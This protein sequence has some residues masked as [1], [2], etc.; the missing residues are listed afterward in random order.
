MP[1]GTKYVYR[2]KPDGFLATTG[3]TEST[4][5]LTTPFYEGLVVDV[6]LDQ[7]HPNYSPDGY[8][9]GTIK[10]RLLSVDNSRD[11]ELLDWADPL[12]T[13]IQEMPLLGELVLVQKVLGNFFYLRKTNLTRILQEHGMLNLNN[14]ISNRSSRL[15]SQITSR[16]EEI[17]PENHKFGNYFKPD[18]RV[19]Q[20][21]HFEGDVLIQGRMGHSIRFGSSQID[22]SS[23]GLAPN[24]LFRT[25]QAKDVENTDC[26][27]DKIFGLIVE[28]INKDASSVWMTSDQV[29]P[30]E[31]TI[32]NV[33]S[34]YRSLKNPPQQYDGASIIIN[35]DRVVLGSKKTHVLLFAQEE[36][37]LNSFNNTSID[38][39]S[40]IVLTANIDIRNLSSRNIDNIADR[41]YTINVGNDTSV[42]AINNVS[43]VSN[44]MFIGSITDD[45]EPLVGGA[46]LSKWLARL[47]LVLMG[48]PPQVLPWTTQKST[49]IPAIREGVSTHTHVITSHGPGRLNPTIVNGLTQL[50]NELAKTNPGQASPSEFAGAPFNSGDNFV[51]LANEVPQIQKNEFKTGNV[52][53]IEN[54]KWLLSEPY[55]KVTY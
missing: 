28:D 5:P 53:V 32:V 37:Y 17:T 13:T 20:L 16:D 33:G 48:N 26:T 1:S 22:P 18:N 44:K 2:A 42:V 8:N 36:I 55:Y 52:T 39:D 38:T 3:T 25:G 19:R 46:S 31:P 11:D 34:F 40:S 29:I 9:V 6:V 49:P 35:S 51:K 7:F 21:K 47:I 12:D 43:F 10:V 30:Y 15:R 54:N 14:Q 23:K 27:T 50:Y 45:E 41:D 4:R 24:L